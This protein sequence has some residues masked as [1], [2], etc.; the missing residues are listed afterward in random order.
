MSE[1]IYNNRVVIN[2]RGATISINNTT[3]KESIQ[4]SQRSGSNILINNLVNSELA[5]NNKQNLTIYDSFETV[6]ND[7]TEY[8]SNDKSERVGRNSYNLKGF[9][10]ESEIQAFED[11]KK[12]YEPIAILNSKFKIKRGGYSFPNG[13]SDSLSGT[14]ATNPVI[15]S[16]VF[17]VNNTFRGYNGL[18]VRSAQTDDVA[19]YSTVP[20][21]GTTRPA[22]YFEIIA[23][24]ILKSAGRTGSN[25]PGVLEFGVEVSPATENGLWEA[26]EEAQNI[27]NKILELQDILS[28][29][30]KRMGDGGD[31]NNFY[32]RNKIETVGASFNDFPSVRIDE[33]GR[34]QPFEM[35]VSDVGIFKN[36]DYVPHVEEIDNASNFPCGQD[37][38]IVGNNYIRNVGSGGISLKTTGSFELGGSTLKTGFKKIN[39]NASH[40]IHIGSE[41]G[42]ELQSLKTIV[43]RTNR[44]VYVECSLGVKNNVII[45]GGLAVEGEA[46]LQHITAPLE[47]QQTQDTTVLGK[48]ATNSDRSLF[49]GECEIGGEYYPVYASSR[50]NLIANYPHS[51]HFNNAA[52]T[53]TRSNADVRKIAQ[54]NGI[55][56]HNNIAQASPQL[57]EKKLAVFME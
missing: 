3:D 10:N 51:H 45:G 22:S 54:F 28:P 32:K 8:V 12:N 25:A 5:T 50:D 17:T 2:Q 24:Q 18:P 48:F 11:W 35:L 7:K 13:E 53:L 26:N 57:H 9:N 39:L 4:I 44:Q 46:Y 19:L 30:E 49:I 6:G 21:H 14:R 23:N 41:N 56:A 33:K 52:M 38:K 29:I 34:S 43:L 42:I 20:D 1:E 47:V 27:S 37:I 40:G 31:E 15:G 36:H 16:S 55:N